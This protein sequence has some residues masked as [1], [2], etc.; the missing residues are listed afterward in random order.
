MENTM[1]VVGNPDRGNS[2]IHWGGSGGNGNGGGN[3]NRNPSGVNSLQYPEA[4]VDIAVGV[5]FAIN[6]IDAGWGFT[7]FTTATLDEAIQSALAKIEQGFI[8]TLPYAGRLLG[9]TFGLLMPSEIAKDEP[10]YRANLRIINTL[11]V[12]KVTSTPIATLSTQ[13]ETV[14]HTRIA[15]VVM[16]DGKQHLALIRNKDF[17]VSVPVV[18]AKPTKRAGV[19]TAAIVPGQPDVHVKINPGKAPTATQ[20]KGVQNE[21]GSARFP[22][23]TAGQHSHEAIVHFPDGKT[24][25][26]YVSVVEVLTESEAS[27]RQ[28]EEARRQEEWNILHPVEAAENAYN[29]AKAAFDAADTTWK[30]L[31]KTLASLQ[32]SPEGR[33]LADPAKYP[34]KSS[35]KHKVYV[36]D[37]MFRGEM[38]ITTE[39]VIDSKTKLDYLL[40]H[41]GLAYKRNILKD[42]KVV[43]SDD[44]EGDK[45]IYKAEYQEYDKL[46]QRLLD[47]KNKISSTEK[48]LAIAVESRKQKE[49]RKNEAEDKFKKESKRNQ[50]GV[51]KGKGKKLEDKWLNDADKDYGSP[52][53]EDIANKLR[54][55]QFKNFDEFRR[56][57]WK[58]VAK[59]P[60]ISKQFTKFNR[61]RMNQGRAPR[62]RLK[63]T[64]GGR[65]GFELHHRNPISKG[66]EVYDIDNI[67]VT[68]PKRHID[69]HKEI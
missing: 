55:R 46:R 32:G 12:D 27:K 60:E 63:D 53:P 8:R 49:Q 69:I 37:F 57:F 24:S 13:Q 11:P 15:D 44:P 33:T 42:T 6:L 35:T 10:E 22:G 7:L 41:D 50:P 21:Q 9:A 26:V 61:N 1:N 36:S 3:G 59:H 51:A 68:T 62:C 43:V 64:V 56:A 52:I 39:A 28:E 48:S 5:P 45:A 23:F 67:N 20:P 25:P 38:D 29:D 47:V 54:G 14:V 34:I 19:F 66:G 40:A 16:E 17:P 58:E 2:G 65:R 31:E 4:Q 18:V 30:N